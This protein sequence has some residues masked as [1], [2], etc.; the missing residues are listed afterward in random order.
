MSQL[1]VTRGIEEE[2]LLVR[3]VGGVIGRAIAVGER[4]STYGEG[5]FY[6]ERSLGGMCFG[7][8]P[9]LKLHW[10]QYIYLAYVCAIGW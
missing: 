10:V 2:E 7:R 4:C 1:A 3:F 5:A 9:S 6:C 8:L